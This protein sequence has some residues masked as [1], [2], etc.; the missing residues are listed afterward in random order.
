[1]NPF[2]NNIDNPYNMPSLPFGQ[3]S[4][5]TV[6]TNMAM[7]GA[8][9][10]FNGYKPNTTY[11]SRPDIDIRI[12]GPND[13]QVKHNLPWYQ[14]AFNSYMD[15]ANA[16]DNHIYNTV[17]NDPV[18]ERR[19]DEMAR[20][21]MSPG[22]A[23]LDE[24]GDKIRSIMLGG[25]SPNKAPDL[26]GYYKQINKN[27]DK[28]K[29]N[30]PTLADRA[31]VLSQQTS[32][33]WA[34]YKKDANGNWVKDNTAQTHTEQMQRMKAESAK[35]TDFWTSL[36]TSE[37]GRENAAKPIN[38]GAEQGFT[39][40]AKANFWRDPRG[41]IKLWGKHKGY[42]WLDKLAD[43]PVLFWG[44]LLAGGIGIAGL[45][46]AFIGSRNRQQGATVNNYYGNQQH[47]NTVPSAS[48][49]FWRG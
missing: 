48:T 26:S 4:M 8:L 7:G 43:D 18:Y 27:T 3:S 1:M 31:K 36:W 5:D 39:D 22:Q 41:Y 47:T 13:V 10:P 21:Y 35:K 23:A 37:K 20:G 17:Y 14:R 29:D 30:T 2:N 24:V 11:H 25:D 16:I 12:A 45:V 19:R 33:A 15:A 42:K 38:Q 9:I 49:S 6:D 44:G 46:S 28:P 40:S 32:K 34:G